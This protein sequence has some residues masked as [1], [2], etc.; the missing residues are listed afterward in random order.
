MQGRRERRQDRREFPRIS[1]NLFPLQENKTL[2]FPSCA[3]LNFQRRF[4]NRFL[5]QLTSHHNAYC[6]ARSLLLPVS[7]LSRFIIY[8]TELDTINFILLIL[9]MF[10]GTRISFMRKK[11]VSSKR[12]RFLFLRVPILFILIDFFIGLLHI[13]MFVKNSNFSFFYRSPSLPYG[14][15]CAVSLRLTPRSCRGIL[16][17]GSRLLEV[18]RGLG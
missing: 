12:E 8:I 14:R 17:R 13:V 18:R 9:S 16:A 5:Y 11:F 10:T 2:S 3:G 1:K 15:S 4:I 7:H 6:F